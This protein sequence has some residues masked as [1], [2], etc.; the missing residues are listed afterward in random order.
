MSIIDLLIASS[1]SMRNN[2]D[3]IFSA[4]IFRVILWR[5]LEVIYAEKIP[6]SSIRVARG[7]DG[8][9]GLLKRGS[10]EASRSLLN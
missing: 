9:L 6:D 10:M 4:L 7:V 2:L 5:Y 1:L 3:Y 8:D